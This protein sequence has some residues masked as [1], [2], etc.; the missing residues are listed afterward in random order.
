MLKYIIFLLLIIFMYCFFETN[1]EQFSPGTDI[2]LLTSKPYY[3]ELDY[4]TQMN[5]YQY[6]YYPQNYYNQFPYYLSRYL[7]EY[8]YR[9]F[10]YPNLF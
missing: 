7:P 4:L 1:V 5:K 10:F 8:L 6:D 9:P 2:Q 3:T